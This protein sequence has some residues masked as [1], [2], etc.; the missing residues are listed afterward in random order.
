MLERIGVPAGARLTVRFTD[1]TAIAGWNVRYAAAA[2]EQA[3]TIRHLNGSDG[4]TEPL[5]LVAFAPP[6]A[7]SWVIEVTVDYPADLGSGAYYWLITV[8]P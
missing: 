8:A 5:D 3:V 6:G 1:G 2:D 7:G 4:P